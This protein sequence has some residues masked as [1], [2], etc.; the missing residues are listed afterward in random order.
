MVL[1]SNTKFKVRSS[2]GTTDPVNIVAG[3][4]QGDTLAQYLFIIYL[5]Y[6]LKMSIGLIKENCLTLKKAKSRRYPPEA[7]T[8]AYYADYITLLEITPTETESLLHS[9]E[10]TTGDINLH[11][12]A[13][14][15]VYMC[16]NL[17]GAIS[18]L[19]GGC[20]K[21]VE[22]FTYLSSSVSSTESDVSMRLAKMWTAIDC[23]LIL[24]KSD[25]SNKII[26]SK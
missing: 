5:D 8:N 7:I 12:D 24:W 10:Q 21:S 18:N 19:N 20:L 16:F 9:L 2:D 3:V 1:F 14:K 4:L 15:T 6:V 22:K 23:L 25:L 13:D 11:V 26:T 17:E